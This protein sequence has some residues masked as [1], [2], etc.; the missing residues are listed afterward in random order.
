[1]RAPP[2]AALEEPAAAAAAG[3]ASSVTL[4]AEV[5][6][7]TRTAL[8]QN[9]GLRRTRSGLERLLEDPHPL[10]RMIG[11]CALAREESRGAHFRDD[12]RETDPA[13]DA[14]HTIVDAGGS[15]RFER[16]D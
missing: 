13:L 9:A 7:A 5:T 11:A 14:M 3:T 4:T 10:A 12:H 15:V 1:M 16:W 2:R 8:W 6:Q